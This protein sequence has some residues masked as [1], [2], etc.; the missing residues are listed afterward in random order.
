MRGSHKLSA[1]KVSRATKPGRYGDG[2]GLWLQV[3]NGG[4]RSW[5]FRYQIDGRARQMGLGPLDVVPLA[6]ARQKAIDARRVLLEGQDPI[7]SKREARAAAKLDTTL[8]VR[9]DGSDSNDGSAN[10]SGHAFLTIQAAVDYA[11]DNFDFGGK[12]VTVKVG[13]G[14]FAGGVI[15]AGLP[16][17]AK[18]AGA[19][20]LVI[21]GNTSSPGSCVI[22]STSAN[23]F[24]LWDHARA[25]IK[26]FQI[27]TTTAGSA[28]TASNHS[29]LAYG[30]I[31]FGTLATDGVLAALHSYVVALANYSIG[32][33][34]SGQ[35]IH[36][37]E[38][39]Y[40]SI[41]NRTITLTGTPAFG[42]RFA[43]CSS[44]KIFAESATFSGSAT[45]VR[46]LVHYNGVIDT[47]GQNSASF[48]PGNSAG[49][50]DE[51]GIW[52]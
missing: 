17:G 26:G 48:F 13:N 45:G 44:A 11:Y 42:A 10:D 27:G 51:G 34:C 40:L 29:Q 31:I 23:G 2:G 9:S 14:S 32:G 12:V 35:H 1:L 28:L 52:T 41:A 38:F 18:S 5:I 6:D 39:S 33:N 24:A 21:E 30:N 15:V 49:T 8:Y 16:V 4:S 36:S 47:S 19:W 50:A 43:G 46:F 20:P 37:T 7:E 22:A 3:A 25:Y